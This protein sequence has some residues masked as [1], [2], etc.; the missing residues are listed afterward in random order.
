MTLHRIAHGRVRGQ[1]LQEDEHQMLGDGLQY[2]WRRF[3]R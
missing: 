3:R 1:L 2:D